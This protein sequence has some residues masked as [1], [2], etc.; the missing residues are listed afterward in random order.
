MSIKI[1]INPDLKLTYNNYRNRLCKIIRLAIQ[2]YYKNILNRYKTNS[3]KL[4]NHLNSVIKPKENY[5]I[6][7]NPNLLNDYFVSVFKQAPLPKENLFTILNESHITD[8]FFLSP[9]TNNEIIIAAN[10]L[11]NSS[12]IG[13]NGTNPILIQNNITCIANRLMYIFNMS[14][15]C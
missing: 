11:S 12:A 6:P 14:F 3:A 13:C 1:K 15:N 10:N 2:Q 4:W 5:L 8:S 9:M 7:I